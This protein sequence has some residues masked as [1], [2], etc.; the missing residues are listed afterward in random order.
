MLT[1]PGALSYDQVAEGISAA[2][3]AAVTHVRLSF[4]DLAARYAA[5]GLAEERAQT[6]AFGDLVVATG[7][8]DRLT[9]D[10]EALI[11]QPPVT[12][13][14]FAA[15]SAP[16]WRPGARRGWVQCRR[17]RSACQRSWVR[18][19]AIRRSPREHRV[20]PHRDRLNSA[21]CSVTVFGHR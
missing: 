17:T 6:L 11:G 15:E 9:P 12:F 5:S 7:D 19:E 14:A 13:Q 8:H 21:A 20:H 18:G 1:G 16:A 10:L 4:E 2:V 3:G